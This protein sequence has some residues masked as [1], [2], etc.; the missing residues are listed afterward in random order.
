MSEFGVEYDR[1]SL[2]LL[3]DYKDTYL[4]FKCLLLL[5]IINKMKNT[6]YKSISSELTALPKSRISEVH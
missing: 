4:L 5:Q 6:S 3:V 1:L 2:N